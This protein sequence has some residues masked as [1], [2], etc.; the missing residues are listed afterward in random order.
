[1]WKVKIWRLTVLFQGCESGSY[2]WF[3]HLCGITTCV[4]C[5]SSSS[6]KFFAAFAPRNGSTKQPYTMPLERRCCAV[7][8]LQIV[9]HDIYHRPI[10][11][12]FVTYRITFNFVMNLYVQGSLLSL[13]W[14]DF[15]CSPYHL[16]RSQVETRTAP[17][18]CSSPIKSMISFEWW[19]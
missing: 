15:P 12:G 1:M 7:H 3:F 18:F 14:R 10:D 2:W 19:W 8:E 9:S 5:T 6:H 17:F 16:V 11:V 4:V 13:S